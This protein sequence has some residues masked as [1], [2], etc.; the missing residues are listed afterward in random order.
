MKFI[1]AALFLV[2]APTL[3]AQRFP[4]GQSDRT[5]VLDPFPNLYQPQPTGAV[6]APQP[7]KPVSVN[8]LLIP[9]K[10][11][12]ELQRSQKAF[13]SGDLRSSNEHLEKALR[14][15]PDC[16]QAHFDLGGNYLRLHD[17]AKGLSE[18]DKSVAIDPNFALG[19]HGRSAALFLMGRF[20]EAEAAARRT[21][22]FDPASSDYRYMLAVAITAQGHITPEART[23]LRQSEDKF[24]AASLLLA[25]VFLNE[26][27]IDDV[28][29]EL[30]T[31]LKAPDSQNKA[32]AQCWL[33][34]LNGVASGTCA[35]QKT[36]PA[37]R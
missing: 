17:Y 3:S 20:T 29:A 8:E 15:Y 32:P 18:Y 9:P 2:L 11:L 22:E 30:Q 21:L 36:F 10:A 13:S 14:I 5:T 34:L 19:Y 16:V 12:K 26:G 24:P 7:V 25:Q 6:P 31:Y 1:A 4:A 33:A 28:V 37:F 27:K 35:A 23:L